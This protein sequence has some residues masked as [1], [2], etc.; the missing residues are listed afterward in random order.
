MHNNIKSFTNNNNNSEAIST[1]ISGSN[2][3]IKN[4]DTNN[5]NNNNNDTYVNKTQNGMKKRGQSSSNL[6]KITQ[7]AQNVNKVIYKN[8]IDEE[9]EG[10]GLL[11]LE[12]GKYV[13]GD[14]WNYGITVFEN[15]E[16]KNQINRR[17]IIQ[18]LLQIKNSIII[19]NHKK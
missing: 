15:K 19:K 1:S 2:N 13:I 7:S 11:C 10:E 12:D 14:N 6:I 17:D 3:N 16:N 9:F 8:K 4:E 18:K 5:N